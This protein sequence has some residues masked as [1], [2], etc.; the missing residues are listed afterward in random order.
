MVYRKRMSSRKYGTKKRRFRR[1]IFRKIPRRGLSKIHYFKK[2]VEL[3]N[4]TITAGSTL[5]FAFSFRL[6]DLPDY[7]NGFS[8]LYDQ[9]RIN[10][11]KVTFTP[12]Y[13]V[14]NSNTAAQ[15]CIPYIVTAL[16]FDNAGTPTS[17]EQVDSYTTSRR[18]VFTRP[19]SRFLRPKILYQIY[20]APGVSTPAYCNA[21]SPW[22]DV[23]APQVSHFGIL[24]FITAANLSNLVT[25]TVNVHATYYVAFRNSR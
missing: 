9:Y 10:A 19:H 24:G 14:Y 18:S 2:A 5:Y 22:V 7:T 4:Q 21:S 16:D 20:N 23:A 15:V 12:Q 11:V 1:K 6:S 13:N 17:L 3:T 25:Q 8:N